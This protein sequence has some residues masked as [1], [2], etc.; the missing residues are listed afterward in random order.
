MRRNLKFAL[1]LKND[2][3]VKHLEELK[4]NLDMDKILEYYK[5]GQLQRW[6]KQNNY[7]EYYD[8]VQNLKEEVDKYLVRSLENILLDK[9]K[10]EEKLF[11]P[12]KKIELKDL[13]LSTE[14]I[15]E[16]C[17]YEDLKTE[18]EIAVGYKE[19]NKKIIYKTKDEFLKNDYQ[20]QIMK[21]I[22]K[23]SKS[24]ELL[25]NYYLK[26]LQDKKHIKFI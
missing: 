13:N 24:L 2:K 14:N 5:N 20:F 6:L 7:L 18:K 16:S 1:I 3:K 23:D 15:K 19:D 25:K 4:C 26:V 22:V 10:V 9:V 17:K 21:E 11:S 8:K 12:I